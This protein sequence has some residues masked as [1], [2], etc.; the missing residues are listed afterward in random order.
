VLTS[1]AGLLGIKYYQIAR[2]LFMGNKDIKWVMNPAFGISVWCDFERQITAEEILK[3]ESCKDLVSTGLENQLLLPL[4]ILHGK[5]HARCR[6]QRA[7]T[8]NII[9]NE[10]KLANQ[11]TPR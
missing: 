4:V 10:Q 8:K 5:S 11:P 6:L 1:N 9:I 3:Y 7:K 2:A